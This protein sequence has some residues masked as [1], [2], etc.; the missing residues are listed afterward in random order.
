MQKHSSTQRHQSYHF[1]KVE[2]AYHQDPTRAQELGL[3]PIFSSLNHKTILEDSASL[4][5]PIHKTFESVSTSISD[6]APL[7]L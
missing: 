2:S 1:H 6:I 4:R 3:I 7:F 5:G